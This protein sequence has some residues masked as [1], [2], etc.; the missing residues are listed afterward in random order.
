MDSP[1]HPQHAASAAPQRA[2]MVFFGVVSVVVLYYSWQ[3]I[4]PYATPILLA[5]V[6]ATF[7]HGTY[8]RLVLRLRGR[9]H[10]AAWIMCLLVTLVVIVPIF[11]LTLLLVQEATS[12]LSRVT[13]DNIMP[14]LN[15]LRVD[16]L[17]PWLQ[18]FAPGVRVESLN[19]EGSIVDIAKKIPGLVVGWSGAL[20]SGTV[21]LLLGFFLML[22]TLAYLYVEGPRLVRQLFYLSPLPDAY[23]RELVAKFRAIVRSTLRGSFLTGLAQGVALAIGFAIVG[24]P[25]AVFWGV[26]TLVFSFLPMVG[27]AIVWGAGA[28]VLASAYALHQP[29]IALW[30]PI[31]LTLWGVLIVSTIDNVLRTFVMQEDV[32][33]PAIVLFFSILGGVQAFGFM[34]VLIGPLL[35]ALLATIIHIY[36]DLFRKQLH[37]QRHPSS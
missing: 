7:T 12:V 33:L 20:L 11:L 13:P 10:G 16:R 25:G 36:K 19:I 21:D 26:V 28:I 17:Q 5:V 27:S 15:A 18:S 14:I 4:S 8:E 31:F 32:H 23:D 22:I 34:G 2:A 3:V 1:T 6:L 24:I 35:F 9:R 30:Q 29:G 37:G